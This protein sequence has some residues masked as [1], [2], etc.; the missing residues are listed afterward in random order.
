MWDQI[1][2]LDI[3]LAKLFLEKAIFIGFF[4]MG[5]VMTAAHVL[6]GGKKAEKCY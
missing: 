6:L 5:Q 2:D 3:C 4:F 1:D